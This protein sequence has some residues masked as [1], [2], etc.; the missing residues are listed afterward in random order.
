MFYEK[1]K[2]PKI[3]PIE[4]HKRIVIP[5]TSLYLGD[6]TFYMQHRP[7]LVDFIAICVIFEA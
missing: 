6:D 3:K 5:M 2:F 4:S 1:T 7:F